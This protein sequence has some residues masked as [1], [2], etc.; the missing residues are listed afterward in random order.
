MAIDLKKDIEALYKSG[1]D[2]TTNFFDFRILAVPDVVREIAD[3]INL[4]IVDNLLRVNKITLPEDS[5]SSQEI[6]VR[7]IKTTKIVG[8]TM[9]VLDLPVDVIVDR[10]WKWYRFFKAWKDYHGNPL[11][12]RDFMH[13]D[14]QWG[15]VIVTNGLSEDDPNFIRWIF[16][17]VKLVKI[18]DISFDHSSGEP[19]TIS[20]GF[21]FCTYELE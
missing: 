5:I 14:D 10:S 2:A 6:T 4:D 16:R 13:L 1:S 3:I 20:L 15:E 7:G 8:R 19:I 21:K 17:H 18:G 11:E 9:T 12:K